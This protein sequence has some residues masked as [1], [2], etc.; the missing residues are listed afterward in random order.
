MRSLGQQPDD[1]DR[2]GGDD[3][4][5]AHPVVEVAAVL[6]LDQAQRPGP[7]D[8]PDVLG[9]VD[10][11]RGDGA[12]LDHRGVAGDRR[13]VDVQPEQLLGDR[14]VA[15]ARDGQE[16]GEPLD[17]A[18]HDGVAVV[19][20]GAAYEVVRSREPLP[21]AGAARAATVWPMQHR[22]LGRSGLSVSRLG[23]GLM[24][25]GN[26]TDE[27]EAREQL[28][29]FLDAGGTLLDTAHAYAGGASEELLGQVARRR[30]PARRGGHRDQGRD[31][32]AP[33]RAGDGHLSRLPAE[34]PRPVAAP[35]RRRLTS[36]S[37]RCTSGPT[38]PRSRR[39]S[40]RWTPPCRPAGRR[41]SAISNWPGWRTAQ[42]AT[43]QRAV[44][45]RAPLV[46]TQVEYSLLNR[47]IEHEVGPGLD[48]ARPRHPALVA[49]GPGRAHRQVPHRHAGGLPRRL[50][51][52]RSSSRPTATKRP[53][54]S[55][56][57]SSRPPTGWA[58]RRSRWRWRGSATGRA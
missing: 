2:D 36:T 27:H 34:L 55:S 11:H 15:G 13:V 40:R 19:H 37:G 20:V 31:R 47:H 9:E 5:P 45:G 33:R 57:R 23:L 12:H 25:W 14:Q 51:T 30:G 48:R 49:A 16:L 29:A 54:P 41:T 53:R 52:C 44:P 26:H 32:H 35:A 1:A 10:D 17:H 21:R 58:G 6:R 28:T 3:D 38:R 50:A 4:V 42:A 24:T 46:S 39:P 43:W 18:E 7:D 56:R 8:P 22:S